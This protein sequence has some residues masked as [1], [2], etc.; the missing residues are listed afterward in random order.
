MPWSEFP[1]PHY[2]H[3]PRKQRA[4]GEVPASV[5][6]RTSLTSLLARNKYDT[7]DRSS[8]SDGVFDKNRALLRAY[9]F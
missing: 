9:N 1:N 5:R 3:A 8:N 6:P 7:G 2:P 4:S